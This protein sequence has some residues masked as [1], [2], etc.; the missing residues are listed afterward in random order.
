M[1]QHLSSIRQQ[2]F[3]V[4]Q[5]LYGSSPSVPP[6]QQQSE[7][8]PELSDILN[9]YIELEQSRN[10]IAT[11]QQQQQDEAIAITEI[12]KSLIEC[13]K[14]VGCTSAESKWTAGIYFSRSKLLIFA[15][16]KFP[17]APGRIN[18]SGSPPAY[19]I[20]SGN[21]HSIAS[22]QANNQQVEADCYLIDRIEF[23]FTTDFHFR[24][25]HNLP[26][27]TIARF[28]NKLF[29]IRLLNN[30]C[31]FSKQ[32]QWENYSVKIVRWSCATNWFR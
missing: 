8:D 13:E 14:A 21:L 28:G 2:P 29:R 9:I 3:H 1:Q 16:F 32:G 7:C 23:V 18:Y 10:N 30:D 31:N 12:T 15:H 4:D 24:T 20:Q 22:Q 25:F 19:P 26:T 11:Q 27:T 5:P 6:N 17:D